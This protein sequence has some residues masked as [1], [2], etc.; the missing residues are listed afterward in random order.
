MTL[1]EISVKRKVAMTAFLIMLLFLGIRMYDSIGIDSLPKFDVPYVQ[2]TTV[3]PGAS[4]EEIEVDVAKRIEDVVASLD[5]LKHTTSVCMEN[6][7]A[8]TLEFVLGTDVDIMVHEVREKLNTIAD[9]FPSAV[10]TPKL[11]KVNINAI[12]VVTLFLTGSK[13]VDELYDYVDETLSDMFSS[14]P[15][16]GE[17]RIHGG[18]EVQLHI[19]LDRKKLSESNLTIAE[20][21]SRINSANLK[22]PAGRIKQNGTEM[23]ITYDAEYRDIQALKDLEISSNVGKR[24]YLGDIAEIKLMSK[25]IR[26][27]AYF[28][29]LPAVQLEIVKKSEANAVKVIAEVKKR[30]ETIVNGRSLPGGMQLHWFKDSGAFI[31]ASV[32]DAWS[33]VGLGILLTAVLLFL[34][35]HDTRSTFTVVISM[36]VSIVISFIAMKAFDYTFDMMTLVAFGC[37]TGVLVTNAVV[38]LEN[39]SKRL[40]EGMDA[41]QASISGTNEVVN[42]VAASALTNVVVFV[43]VVLMSSVVGLL[44]SPFAGVMV[45]ATLASLF[46]S[47]TLTPILASIFFAKE[48]K[49]PNR[50]SEALFR[51]WDWGYSRLE[52]A[53]LKSIDFTCR[54][55]GAVILLVLAVSLLLSIIS[56]PHIS[57]SFIPIN[58]KSE[59]SIT[60]EFPTNTA[61]SASRKRSLEV[62]KEID[63]LPEVES[64]GATVGY[65]NAMAGQVSEGVHLTQIS[66]NL[67]DKDKRKSVFQVADDL[68]AILSQKQNLRY[69]VN[70]PN[71]TGS[72][73]AEI[74]TYIAGSDF[75]ILQREAL[76]A[77]DIL[78]KSGIASDIDSSIRAT[79]P[80]T[81]VVPNR[82][83]LRNL[84]IPESLLGTSILGFFDGV[85]AGSYKVGTRTYDI[86][87]K[88]NDI[89]GFQE[90]EN[91]VIGSMKGKPVNINVLADF[92]SS[93]VSIS[94]IR[95]DKQRAA[96]IYCNPASGAAMGDVVSLLKDKVGKNLP[97]GYKLAF[98][99]QAEMMESGAQDFA[100][101]FVIATVMTYLLIAAIME[102]W[103]RPF[104]ILVTVPLGFIGMFFTLF[105]ASTSMSMVG[106]L[107][108]VMMIGIVV[109]NA[110]LI[111]D[112]TTV[113]TGRGVGTHEAMLQ[114]MRAKFRPILMTSIASVVGMLPMAFGTGLGSELRS[115]CGLGVVGGL[116]FSAAMTLYL[117][118][119][120]YFKFVRDSALPEESWRM[121]LKR[122]CGFV[123]AV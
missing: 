75:A 116:T 46:V 50:V 35:L 106:M 100:N 102:S 104:I 5:G 114:A 13:S 76:K 85:E 121:R 122:F 52:S 37:S 97:P 98:Y 80:R 111:M 108:G 120:L 59:I 96:W 57:M 24:I 55:S 118:P 81:N 63:K 79:K 56:L 113:L 32:D 16:V 78:R 39:I 58:D 15:G 9:D 115:S 33:S 51:L 30:Y 4:P 27:E 44:I 62:I 12:P 43:P 19:V 2:I 10:E 82:A 23:S 77:I 7:C 3:Y 71:S 67:V 28:N 86:R 60:L 21:I 61:L 89:E 73:G 54:H 83:V 49:K 123:K 91:I 14:I 53:F 36:P 69:S 34:F 88:T 26:Q 65:I 22:I 84:A 105:L 64:V 95:E 25:E 11:S 101:V 110:I 99:G 31:H 6:V 41:P 1:S 72:S 29:G 40:H 70:I 87:I 68:R 112:E 109:N 92:E 45:V 38:V 47:F 117:I 17:I 20:V 119:A 66:L 48:R 8:I 42:A 94:M 90:A 93:P 18:N 103:A 74:I 107:G